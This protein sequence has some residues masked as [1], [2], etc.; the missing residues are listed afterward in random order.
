MPFLVEL[1]TNLKSLKYGNDRP[2]GGSSNQPYIQFPIQ[3]ATTPST[4]VELYNS[5]RNSLDYPVRGGGLNFQVGT[6]NFTLAS[7]IDKSRIKKFFED[8]PRG[9]AFIQK[10]SQLQYSNPKTETGNTLSGRN[11]VLPLPGLLENTRVYNVG[12]NTLDQVGLQ[13]TGYHL[14]RHGTQPF[15]LFEKQYIDIVGAQTLANASTIGRINRL[16][17]LQ[18]LK[19]SK[20]PSQFSSVGNNLDL[21]RVNNLGISLNRNI[22]FQYLGGPGSAY[23]IGSTT[24]KRAVDTTKVTSINAMT[25]DALMAQ[26]GYAVDGIQDFRSK[27]DF[28]NSMP[29]SFKKDSMEN[30]LNMGNPGTR[31]KPADYTFSAST[32]KLSMLNSYLFKNDSAPWESNT[33]SNKDLIKFVFEAISNDNPNY[34]TAIF[35]R[36]FL[37]SITDNNSA[38]LNA[39]KYLGRAETFRTYQGFDRSVSFSFKIAIQ[40]RAELKPLYSKLNNLISQVYPDYSKNGYMRA[41]VVRLTIGDYFYRTPGFLESVNVTIDGTTSWEINLE[42]SEDV[43]QLP[44]SVDVNIS[45]KPIFDVLPKRTTEYNVTP[46]IGNTRNQFLQKTDDSSDKLLAT[47]EKATAAATAAVLKK[48]DVSSIKTP[49]I[50]ALTPQQITDKIL[51]T[52]SFNNPNPTTNNTQL[53]NRLLGI[54]TFNG[55]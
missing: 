49:F 52:N 36:A 19:L 10:Q 7:Q 11:Q 3:D 51:G 13:G 16:L 2:G 44:H 12:K 5:N 9:T 50:K 29:W 42:N 27:V 53:T 26:K 54:N 4:I 39:F 43:A 6:Q 55:G 34:S 47:Q 17:I 45:F 21:S 22:L 46:L 48:V 14:K 40:S 28:S 32:D 24:I 8:K 23:G 35:F 15:N 38:E 18:Q 37:S 33:D 41:P 30:R 1:K 20:N 31:Q 25:Y